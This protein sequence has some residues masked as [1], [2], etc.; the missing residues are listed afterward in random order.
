MVPTT[1]GKGWRR[2]NKV[3][4]KQRRTNCKL[5]F[6]KSRLLEHAQRWVR[7][8]RDG[9]GQAPDRGQCDRSCHV[10]R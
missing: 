4:N 5:H 3:S 10:G 9:I 7:V 8:E 6:S 1:Q 2:A